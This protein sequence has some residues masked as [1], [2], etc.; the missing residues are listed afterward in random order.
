MRTKPILLCFLA[1]VLLPLAAPARDL[2][3]EIEVSPFGG[4]DRAASMNGHGEVLV[5]WQDG[6]STVGRLFAPDNAPRGPEFEVAQPTHDYLGS[7]AASIDSRGFSVVWDEQSRFGGASYVRRFDARG[8]PLTNPVGVASLP[9]VDT[10]PRGRSVVITFGGKGLQGQRFDAAGKPIGPPFPLVESPAGGFYSPV[11]VAAD[12]QGSFVVVWKPASGELL[13][14]RFDAGGRPRGAVFQ[15]AGAAGTFDLAGNGQGSFVALWTSPRGVRARVYKPTGEA[16]RESIL[17]ASRIT[18]LESGK[19]SVA[20]DAAGRFLAT[21]DCCHSSPLL[22]LEVFGRFFEASGAPLDRAF[23]LALEDPVP[24]RDFG[25]D[26]AGGPAGEFFAVWQR[27][28]DF[29]TFSGIVGRRLQWARRGDDLCL[30][31]RGVFDCD[32]VHDGGAKTVGVSFGE[33]DALPLLGDFDGDGR[34]D[35]CVYRD[36]RFRCDTAHDG[37]AAEVDLAFG[38]GPFALLGDLDGDGRDDPCVSQGDQVLCDTAHN[39]GSAEVVVNI[40]VPS[41]PVFLADEDGD[42]DGDVCLFRIDSLLCD[43]GDDGGAFEARIPFRPKPGDYL[44]FGDVD[45]DGRDDPCVIRRNRLLCDTA[46]EGVYRVSYPF[47]LRAGEVPLLGDVNG[48]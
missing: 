19:V 41:G 11:K 3:G 18:S 12:G 17:V 9:T 27:F 33:A 35:Y 36:G 47:P 43:T 15:I 30:F 4:F 20:M 39:G 31:S 46:H 26:A 14:R 10:D 42:G 38:Q 1:L 5:V 24:H 22:P 28:T 25:A 16:P 6:V 32:V 21:W 8:E 40:G 37:G 48:I 13:G 23:R 2:T 45:D 44:L 7:L 34:D 29:S